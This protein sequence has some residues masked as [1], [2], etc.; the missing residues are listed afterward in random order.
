MNKLR[1]LIIPVMAIVA[2]MAG[3]CKSHKQKAE[4]V[5]AAELIEAEPVGWRNVYAPVS[6]DI[7]QPA[8]FSSSGRMTMVRGESIYLSLRMFGMEVGSVYADGD[9]AVMAMRMPKKMLME[10]PVMDLFIRG[11]M[12][13]TDV[14]E[15]LLG[16]PEAL[17]KLPS[18]VSYDADVT[19]DEAVVELHATYAGK[20]LGV[21]L[22][23][24]L[25]RA[26]WDSA[27]PR[28]WSE[29]GSDYTKVTP[30]QALRMLGGIL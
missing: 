7:I 8:Q 13:L 29:P 1:K 22:T 10:L 9:R 2:L 11:G 25:R 16:N 14:Q 21:R 4:A 6:V 3:G 19:D 24:N 30:A 20:P 28:K 18:A 15:A 12:T 23:W 26:E 17:A 5:Q 27:S